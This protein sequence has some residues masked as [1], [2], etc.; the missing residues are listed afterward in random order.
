MPHSA[1]YRG[2]FMALFRTDFRGGV[3]VLNRL[4]NH[5]ALIRASQLAHLHSMS[6]RAEATDLNPYRADLKITGTSCL[7]V[8]DEN[9]W[10]W[11]RGTGVGP[12]PC[13]SALQALE[14][15]CDQM[16]T[17]GAPIGPLV[18]VLLADCENLAMVALIVGMLVRHTEVAD[19]LLDPYFTEPLIWR[20]EFRRIVGEHGMLAASSDGIEAPERRKWSLRDAAMF[21]ALRAKDER[22]ADLRALGKTLVDRARSKI[23]QQRE[24]DIAVDGGRSGEDIEL[25]LAPVRAW[26]SSLD[27]NKFQ[28]RET[29]DGLYI[30]ATPPQEVVQALQH[31]NED[32]ERATEQIRLVARYFIELRKSHAGAI[33]PDELNADIATARRLIEETP[34]LSVYRPWDVSAL[35]AAAALEAHLLRQ[36][37][38]PDNVLAFAAETVIQVSEGEAPQPRYEFEET[39]FEEGADRNAARVL[40]LLLMPSA[41]PL[42]A[43]VDG[44]DGLATFRRVSA[45]GSH[46]AQAVANEV[47][48]HLARGLDHLWATQCVQDG[49]CHH[50]VGWQ[51]VMQTMKGCVS[52]GWTHHQP[53]RRLFLKRLAISLLECLPIRKNTRMR[54]IVAPGEPLDEWLQNTP[55]DLILPSRLDASIRALAPAAIANICVSTQSRV[56]LMALIDTQRRSFLHGSSDY[57]HRGGH[58]LVSARALLTLAGQGDVTPIHEHI[59][60]YAD[61]P[62]LLGNLLRALSAAAEETPERAAAAQLVW[63]SVVRHVLDLR[64]RSHVQ[65]RK[66]LNG[67]MALASLIPNAAY[68]AQYLYRELQEQPIVWWEPLELR[69]EVEEWLATAVGR[70][71]CVDQLI[72]FLRVLTLEDQARVGLPWVSTLVLGNPGDIAKGSFLLAEWLIE[73]RSAAAA[74]AVGLS[75]R[76]QQVVDALVVEGVTRLAPYSE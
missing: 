25:Q 72:G 2:P 17:A 57:D 50:Q 22:A 37:D 35:V 45:A 7:F 27:R 54:T 4:L 6:R 1:W 36:V 68:E 41:A 26:A 44:A 18:S 11:Y 16:I 9:V 12:Y 55:G 32:S 33:G 62:A 61:N 15:T 23:D 8:G 74:A 34:S 71:E 51:F 58:S 10:I 56:L 14:L 67:E 38:L 65:F 69:P 46:L 3:V 30:Q 39:Y 63:P 76:W 40:P 75:A 48:L 47:R 42:R 21:T 73:T 20:Y 43:I 5:A 70:V 64:S 13:M 52:T 60:A 66:D 24:A 31:S 49:P 28:V 19:N 53:R 29:P 59:D